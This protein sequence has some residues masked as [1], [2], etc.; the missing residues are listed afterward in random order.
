MLSIT[1]SELI[2]LRETVDHLHNGYS[3]PPADIGY[4][5]E[6]CDSILRK[7]VEVVPVADLETQETELLDAISEIETNPEDIMDSGNIVLLA[8]MDTF[9]GDSNVKED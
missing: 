2:T 7:N 4:C 8:D 3:V 5:L 9:V 1:K 6:I